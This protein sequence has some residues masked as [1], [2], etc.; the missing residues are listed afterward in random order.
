MI[1]N[2]DREYVTDIL[3]RYKAA[4][5]ILNAGTRKRNVILG[6]RGTEILY[7][8]KDRDIRTRPALRRHDNG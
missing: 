1:A 6:G 7:K 2:V 3:K 5:F 8:L 4:G